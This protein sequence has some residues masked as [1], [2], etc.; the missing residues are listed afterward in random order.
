[1]I[2]CRWNLVSFSREQLAVHWCSS[3]ACTCAS[4][5]ASWYSVQSVLC[6][7]LFTPRADSSVGK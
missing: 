6:L 1:M 4:K 3:Y 7:V 5:N 2:F